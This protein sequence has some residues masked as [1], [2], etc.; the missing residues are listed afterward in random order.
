M[1]KLVT[2]PLE[3]SLHLVEGQSGLRRTVTRALAGVLDDSPLLFAQLTCPSLLEE[4]V[5][6]VRTPGAGR[7][8]P[9]LVDGQMYMRSLRLPRVGRAEGGVLVVAS[10]D[11][12]SLDHAGSLPMLIAMIM[13]REIERGCAEAAEQAALDMANRDPATGLGNRRAW[14][15]TLQLESARATRTGRPLTV[16]VLDLDGLKKVNDSHGHAAGDELIAMTA[17]GLTAARR[18]TDVVCRLGGDEFGIAAPDT[19]DVQ[20]RLLVTR[21]RA[22]LNAKGVEFSVGWAVSGTLPDDRGHAQ[23]VWHQADQL[24][25]LNKRERR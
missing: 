12:Q 23:D 3:L 2:A 4:P 11:Q 16:I 6:A 8:R 10:R 15:D 25:Y 20:A 14:M 18:A 24:M 19:D 13:D 7:D 1:I 22:A 17:A 5:T 9:P 21:V